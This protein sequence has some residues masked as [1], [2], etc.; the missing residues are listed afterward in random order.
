MAR[1]TDS[2][3]IVFKHL[4]IP[5]KGKWGAYYRKTCLAIRKRAKQNVIQQNIPTYYSEKTHRQ[6]GETQEDRKKR[7]CDAIALMKLFGGLLEIRWERDGLHK[8]LILTIR[9][10]EV[11]E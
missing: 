5:I 9:N 11:R 6:I 3:R 2:E 8:P 10:T 7:N 4:G 1:W